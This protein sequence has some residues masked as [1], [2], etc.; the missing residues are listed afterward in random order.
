M[1]RV[2]G[3]AQPRGPEHTALVLDFAAR[4]LFHRDAVAPL[5]QGDG[6][7]V[8]YD[9]EWRALRALRP[10]RWKPRGTGLMRSLA[11]R[12]HLLVTGSGGETDA[13]VR[14]DLGIPASRR[15]VHAAPTPAAFALR[16]LL[17][18]LRPSS[19][20][21]VAD[22]RD[23]RFTQH[24]YRDV[25]VGGYLVDSF[26]RHRRP[27]F[28]FFGPRLPALAIG[29]VWL[30]EYLT[31]VDAVAALARQY[32]FRTLLI[33]HAVYAE[34]GLLAHVVKAVLGAR[35]QVFH[36][37]V[38]PGSLVEMDRLAVCPYAQRTREFLTAEARS[39]DVPQP[40]WRDLPADSA[41]TRDDAGRCII[42]A[43]HCLL[44]ANDVHDDGSTV[45]P[46]YLEWIRHSIE[47]LRAAPHVR[48]ILRLHPDRRMYGAAEEAMYRHLFRDLP[49]NCR[50]LAPEDPEGN[51]CREDAVVVTFRGSI[52]LELACLGKRPV[53][54]GEPNCPAECYTP[55]RSRR[56]YADFLLGGFRTFDDHLSADAVALADRYRQ[57]M[58]RALDY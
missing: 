14:A 25:A 34:S 31:H 56:E 5:F 29:V 58:K 26:L 9:A 4:E 38:S 52:A 33:N 28:F 6:T 42:L 30:A 53:A 40:M 24:R 2:V 39:A 18:V 51:P 12:A 27:V 3:A 10:S 7:V 1:S 13:R 57:A 19:W 44:D 16:L 15:I 43:M 20:H 49:D 32:R 46:S 45:H 41:A 55:I 21:M 8:V 22:I 54:V 50:V 47:V 48:C 11:S 36:S 35:V 17:T 37:M 23:G